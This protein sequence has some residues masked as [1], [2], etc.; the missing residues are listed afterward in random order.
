M[1]EEDF[2]D[3]SE[4]QEA[5]NG[6]ENEI[7]DEANDKALIAAAPVQPAAKKEATA[8]KHFTTED[9][10]RSVQVATRNWL[11]ETSGGNGA[12]KPG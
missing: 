11:P 6:A 7:E 1:L 2:E 8:V 9:A 5:E 3:E 10:R 12:V 4:E